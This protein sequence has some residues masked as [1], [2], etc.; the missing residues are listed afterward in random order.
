MN[1]SVWN[2]STKQ[3]WKRLLTAISQSMKMIGR[4][5]TETSRNMATGPSSILP[6]RRV[7]GPSGTGWSSRWWRQW[8]E[9][10]N[11]PSRGMEEPQVPK[12][13]M[14]SLA[15]KVTRSETG[16]PVRCVP[17][18]QGKVTAEEEGTD[19]SEKKELDGCLVIR[20]RNP[21]TRAMAK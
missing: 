17:S 6:S 12:D 5:W 4:T 10:R 3:T 14:V 21:R 9:T 8:R 13:A 7:A 1:T 2:I 20:K 15:S 11:T 18:V 19:V 16:Q